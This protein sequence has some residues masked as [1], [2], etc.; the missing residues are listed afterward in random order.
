LYNHT[1]SFLDIVH[2][3]R[4]PR[5]AGHV[6]ALLRFCVLGSGSRGSEGTVFG[7]GIVFPYGENSI[8]STAGKSSFALESISYRPPTSREE[9]QSQ[10]SA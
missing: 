10:K 2:W 8:L 7:H 1:V 3:Q 6:V 4:L 9:R 5:G